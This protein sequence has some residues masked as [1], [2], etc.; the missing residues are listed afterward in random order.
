MKTEYT[1]GLLSETLTGENTLP[2]HL[3]QKLLPPRP[4]PPR[5]VVG[6]RAKE[7][8]CAV[9]LTSLRHMSHVTHTHAAT[10]TQRWV[11]QEDQPLLSFGRE[12]ANK[13]QLN[14]TQTTPLDFIQ[15]SSW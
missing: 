5:G 3:P 7:P 2:R 12:N 15:H 14:Y 6:S 1:H 8:A 10:K 4:T 13:S 11:P 9:S